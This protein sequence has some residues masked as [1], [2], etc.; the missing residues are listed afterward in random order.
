MVQMVKFKKHSNTLEGPFRHAERLENGE[1]I[2]RFRTADGQF[3]SIVRSAD[4][5]PARKVRPGWQERPTI[6]LSSAKARGAREAESRLEAEACWLFDL[7]PAVVSYETQPFTVNYEIDGRTI[8]TYPDIEL[9]LTSGIFEI[10]QIKMQSTYEK[11]LRE[12]P[13]FRYER[14]TFERLG[15]SYKVMTEI[16]IRAE[17]KLS[18]L[19]LLRH[20]RKRPVSQEIMR[21]VIAAVGKKPGATIRDVIGAFQAGALHEVDIFALIAQHRIRADLS[22]PIRSDTRLIAPL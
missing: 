15:W 3:G 17:P 14:E 18:N 16:E 1:L 5:K 19:K 6:L 12:N 4:G 8:S 13:R 22:L 7:D 9:K 11:H 20:Y 21:G 10:A 2:L